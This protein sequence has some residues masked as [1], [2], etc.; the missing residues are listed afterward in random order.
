MWVHDQTGLDQSSV[1]HR[2]R[3]HRQASLLGHNHTRRFSNHQFHQ[4]N[5][6]TYT[7][8]VVT[9]KEL[10]ASN[11]EWW[12]A[13]GCSNIREL[14]QSCYLAEV[15]DTLHTSVRVQDLR[16]TEQASAMLVCSANPPPVPR[17]RAR[18]AAPPRAQ[19]GRCLID[20]PEPCQKLR[21]AMVLASFWAL[22]I[23]WLTLNVNSRTELCA[24]YYY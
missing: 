15:G 18:L 24:C 1:M 8:T 3:V 11:T 23:T 16:A 5:I 9:N 22:G 6:K 20:R 21:V 4:R 12:F 13:D 7:A 10:S 19:N 17:P 2:Q 14:A